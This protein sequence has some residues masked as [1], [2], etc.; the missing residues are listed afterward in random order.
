MNSCFS[1]LKPLLL[2]LIAVSFSGCA[3]NARREVASGWLV[4]ETVE[5]KLE[6]WKWVEQKGEVEIN[7]TCGTNKGY[8]FYKGRKT[9]AGFQLF[10]AVVEADGV[11]ICTNAVFDCEWQTSYQLKV[12]RTRPDGTSQEML[13]NVVT[14][15]GEFY[16]K[17]ER[18]LTF[19]RRFPWV[20]LTQRYEGVTTC[21]GNTV[22]GE[23]LVARFRALQE[24]HVRNCQEQNIGRTWFDWHGNDP[25]IEWSVDYELVEWRDNTFV[26]L[27]VRDFQHTHRGGGASAFSA[28]NLW[29]REGDVREVKLEEMF[30]PGTQYGKV[31]QEFVAD[32]LKRRKVDT[33][34]L[35][36]GVM[37]HVFT[38]HGILCVVPS[39]VGEERVLVP[40]S[41][42]EA[43]LAKSEFVK[44]V[45]N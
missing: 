31:I 27:L 15:D 16:S 39:L 28:I 6:R 42:L 8:D 44:A 43:Y 17:L 25:F 21:P 35:G 7:A 37:A 38:R 5:G 10:E 11:S 33:T 26:G 4:R 29:C 22:F 3:S 41:V 23:A 32:D 1:T 9:K 30:V 40:W 2:V 45:R 24:Q 18:E 19:N 12:K 20:H 34:S 14:R 13:F 36:M